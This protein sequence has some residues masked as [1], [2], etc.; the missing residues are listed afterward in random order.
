MFLQ[1]LYP[2][3]NCSIKIEKLRMLVDGFAS[4]VSVSEATI[5]SIRVKVTFESKNALLCEGVQ[6][7]EQ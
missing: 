6:Q 2:Y 7:E 1:N 5:I 4:G 3:F